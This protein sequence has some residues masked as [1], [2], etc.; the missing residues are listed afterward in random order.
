MACDGD[1]QVCGDKCIHAWFASA[2]EA[3]QESPV[4]SPIH[5]RPCSS[6]SNLSDL[7]P[8][9]LDQVLLHEPLAET[10]EANLRDLSSDASSIYE[11]D[12]NTDHTNMVGARSTEYAEERAEVELLEAQAKKHKEIGKKMQA[13]LGRIEAI[14]SSLEEAVGPGYSDTQNL[15]VT[16]NSKLDY[17]AH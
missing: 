5:S 17:S 10:I 6:L 7:V 2:L 14:G 13:C 1:K 9:T 3:L 8:F 4:R 12:L 16:S 15:Q 11:D